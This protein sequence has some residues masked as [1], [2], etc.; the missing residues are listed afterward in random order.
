M[1][2]FYRLILR[3]IQMPE[4]VVDAGP[5]LPA[6]LPPFGKL[7]GCRRGGRWPLAGVMARLILIVA[8][9]FALLMVARMVRGVPPR[10]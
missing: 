7:E 10:G 4:A 3:P 9:V 8:I 1:V 2:Y 6:S 5:F